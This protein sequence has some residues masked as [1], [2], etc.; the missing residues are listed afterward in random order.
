MVMPHWRHI[1]AK[2][3]GTEKATI[4]EYPQS[5]HALPHWKCLMQ[6]F[7][8]FPSINLPEQE[9]DDQYTNTS[10]SIR[11]HIYHIIT[12][13]STHGRLPLTDQNNCCKCKTY[14]VSEQL[15]KIYTR[16][17]LVMMKT[18]IYNF[19]TSF[20]I[21]AIQNLA[22]HV[23]RVQILGTNNCGDS[24]RTAFKRRESFQDV[25]CRRDHDE[26]SVTSFSHQIQSE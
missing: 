14:S 18:S 8:K 19:H 6:C 7:Y 22:F 16:K 17:Y 13:C 25:L 21:P 1:C 12:R 5:Y 9:M 15:T 23:P 24:C 26:T 3:S 10:P 4:C 20:C 2:A 11:F